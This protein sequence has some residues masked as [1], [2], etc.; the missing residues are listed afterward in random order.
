[1]LSFLTGTKF[2]YNVGPA[3]TLP[4]FDGGRLRSELGEAAAGYDIAV[5]QYN[6]TLITAL[7]EISDQLIRRASM[8]KQQAFAG[9]SVASAQKTYDIALVAYK[10]GLTDYL[11]VLN[12]QSLLFHQQQ[13]QQQVQAARLTAHA[14]LVVALGGGLSAGADAPAVEKTLPAKTPAVLAVFDH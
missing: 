4:I 5:A 11:N 7:K 8:D 6:Q 10:R 14:E 2:N 3:I 9:E 12:A 1:M 13:I